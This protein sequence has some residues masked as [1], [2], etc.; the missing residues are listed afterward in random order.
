VHGFAQYGSAPSGYPLLRALADLVDL[1]P[2]E[3]SENVAQGCHPWL[4]QT[5]TWDELMATCRLARSL[6][7]GL[8]PAALTGPESL[9]LR[10][11]LAGALDPQYER[12]LKLSS[13]GPGL[14]DRNPVA[15][16]LDNTYH[17]VFPNRAQL[18]IIYPGSR[19]ALGWFGIRL[20]RPVDLAM[21]TVRAAAA[22]LAVARQRRRAR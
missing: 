2:G 7:L 17:A 16:F 6:E 1:A 11:I 13:F 12:A 8:P 10:H 4:V 14:T 3:P 19:S 21:R 22:E 20:Y 9:V 15:T 5:M 18:E